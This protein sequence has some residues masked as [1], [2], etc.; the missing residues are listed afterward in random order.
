MKKKIIT[1]LA[2]TLLLSGCGEVPKLQDGKDAVISFKDDVKISIDTM[3]K[4]MKDTYALGTLIDLM[5][6][7]ILEKEYKNDLEKIKEEADAETQRIKDMFGYD[8]KNY[9]EDI[10]LQYLRSAYGVNTVE[11]LEKS[12]YLNLLRD[13]AAEDY[14]ESLL[15]EKEM[16]AYYDKEIVGDIRASHI[17]ITS[18][19]ESGMSSEEKKNKDAEALKKAEELIKKLKESKDL[20]KD[21]EKLAK[22]NSEDPGSK[23]KGGDLDFFNKDVNV[24]VKEFENAA[25]A[26]KKGEMTDKPIK[27]EHGYHIILKTDEKEKPSFEDSKDKVISALVDE[28][29]KEQSVLKVQG[30]VEM[31][32]KYNMKIE[33]SSLA[34]QYSQYM[35]YLINTANDEDKK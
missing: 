28:K 14:T 17:L 12:V 9:N 29:L 13:R 5:D 1:L 7:E 20:A 35:N 23:D 8:G 26:L 22:E 25:Y 34:E 33:D 30:I 11:A 24:M 6:K 19:A 32:K 4:E 10:F 27:T 21:F 15:K 3:Y 2:F 16:K 31:R 18:E